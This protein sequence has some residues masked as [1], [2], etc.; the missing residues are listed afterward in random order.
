M[1]KLVGITGGIGSGKTTFSNHLKKLGYVVHESDTV[2][3]EIYNNPKKQFLSFIKEKISR[4]ATNHNKINK[5]EIA[6]VI[7]NNNKIKKLLEKRIHKEVQIS[8]EAFIKKYAKKKKKIIFADIPLLLE[9]RLEKSFDSVICIISS[10][11]NRTKRVLKNKKFTKENLNK[12]FK[13]QTT[14]KER[15]KRS[16]IIINNNKTK[17]DFIFSVEK[18]LTGLIK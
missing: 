12:I 6:N 17:K 15:K 7:F 10:K 2:V 11:K 1:T 4:E 14:D 9:N 18:V 13:A 8:R 3:S 16:Q 5:A